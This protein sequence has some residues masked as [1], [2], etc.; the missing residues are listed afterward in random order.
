MEQEQ[1]RKQKEEFLKRQQ[2]WREEQRQA[3]EFKRQED[4]RLQLPDS[5][6]FEQ[7]QNFKRE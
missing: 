1:R 7:E 6:D 5:Y 4:K 3:K 2:E